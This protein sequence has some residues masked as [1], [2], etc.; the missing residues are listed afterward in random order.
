M[1]ET[2][3]E[4]VMTDTVPTVS[5][6]TPVASAA[7]RL[8]DPAV[9]ALVVLDDQRVVGIVTESDFVALVAETNEPVSVEA[10]MSTPVVTVPSGTPT[11]L[12]ADRMHEAGV[13]HLPVVDGETYRGLVSLRSLSPF[14]SRARLDVTWRGEPIHLDRG[15]HPEAITDEPD[16]RA[17]NG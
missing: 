1:I 4:A 9:P 10:I 11:G 15:E 5:P 2:Y 17:M 12:A 14:L 3:V 16:D 6:T 7:Q 13:R 8:R